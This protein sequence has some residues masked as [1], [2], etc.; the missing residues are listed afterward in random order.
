[1]KKIVIIALGLL[2]VA[3]FSCQRHGNEPADGGLVVSS[4][5]KG[6][7]PTRAEA[8]KDA[9]AAGDAI[10]IFVVPYKNSITPGVLRGDGNYA[11]NVPFVA[12]ADKTTFKPSAADRITFPNATSH[13]D[14]Y[15]FGLHN[16]R[17]NNLGADPKNSD[18]TMD[19]DQS[20]AAFVLRNDLMTA[21]NLNVAPTVSTV[22]LEFHHRFSK[23]DIHFTIPATY[24]GEAVKDVKAVYVVNT[25]IKA[26]VN[27]TDTAVMPL[28]VA[29]QDTASIKSYKALGAALTYQYEAIVLPQTVAAG[30]VVARIVLVVGNANKEVSFDCITPGDLIYKTGSK[31]KLTLV[32]EGESEVKITGVTI[33]PWGKTTDNTAVA[34]LPARQLFKVSGDAVKMASITSVKMTIDNILYV[35]SVKLVTDTLTC[36]Y[37]QE[38]GHH[39]F[40]LNSVEFLNSKGLQVKMF[41][42]PWNIL[43][44]PTDD[45]YKEVT[46]TFTF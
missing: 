10:G 13:I 23:I 30:A 12:Q 24:K 19:V 31:S 14:I 43:G 46:T 40:V 9:F 6:T 8:S 4:S 5:I 11:D 3:Q 17:Y 44:R 21:Q 22:P 20:E 15:A 37:L 26:T 38:D 35:G 34:K 45:N 33:M 16:V 2:T 27:M 41:T 39:S 1:M 28:L 32:F 18:W 42:G 7:E 25:K 29:S 36:T